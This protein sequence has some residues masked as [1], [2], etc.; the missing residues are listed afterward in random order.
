MKAL[1]LIGVSARAKLRRAAQGFKQ[2]KR[3]TS[4]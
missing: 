1:D 3:M 4:R 2:V